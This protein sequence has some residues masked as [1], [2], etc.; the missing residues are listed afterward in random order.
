MREGN[1][2][3][4]I[5]SYRQ[6]R[7]AAVSKTSGSVFKGPAVSNLSS[8]SVNTGL[9]SMNREG[10]ADRFV[11]VGLADDPFPLT[12]TLSLSPI[13]SGQADGEREKS[14]REFPSDQ[15][16]NGVLLLSAAGLRH[17]RDPN[18]WF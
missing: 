4:G 16:E 14:V 2:N 11:N 6:Q 5:K 10:A 7:S 18:E 8:L 15:N 13:G 1:M 9:L 3:G 12:P 17:S